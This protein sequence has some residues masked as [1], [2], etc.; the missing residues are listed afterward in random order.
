MDDYT[1][2]KNNRKYNVI[3]DED[4]NRIRMIYN[5]IH[6]DDF[7]DEKPYRILSLFKTA[8]E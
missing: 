6:G 8:S 5:I 4:K 7:D 3:T 2:A 1:F